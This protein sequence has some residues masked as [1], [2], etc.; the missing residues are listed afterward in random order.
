MTT[1]TPTSSVAECFGLID[2]L[3]KQNKEFGDKYKT[4]YSAQ[5]F[6]CVSGLD[7]KG[8]KAKEQIE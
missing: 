6:E 7:L 4:F 2:H 8:I 3:E 5:D 1:V